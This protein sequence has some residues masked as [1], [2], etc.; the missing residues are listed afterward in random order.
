MCQKMIFLFSLL[1]LTVHAS[2]EPR[3]FYLFGHMANSLEEVDD[4]LQQG[5]NALEADFTFASNGTALKL[6]H[7][8]LCDCGRDCK[9][10]TEVTAYLSYLRNSVNEG[11]KYADK[12]LLFYADTKTSDLSGD[13]V[14][15]AGVSMAN[16]LMSY[17]WNNVPYECMLNVILSVIDVKYKD[18]LRGALKT[19]SEAGNSSYYLDHV[20]FDVSGYNSLDSIADMYKELGI[21]GH[22]WQGDGITNCLIKI[23]PTQRTN[24]VIERRTADTTTQNYVDKAY[25]WTVDDSDTISRFLSADVDGMLTNKPANVLAALAKEPFSSSYRLA[26]KEDNPWQRIP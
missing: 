15:Q 5:V 17:L 7:G 8:P 14:Y 6:Y 12:M 25:V 24:S 11:G 2:D 16:N 9:K 18:L 3:P 13:S 22:R 1:I 23:Y 20:G 21:D 4:F 10:S 26:T 19:L